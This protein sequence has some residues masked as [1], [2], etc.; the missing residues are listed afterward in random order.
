MIFSTERPTFAKH[1]TKEQKNTFN[2]YRTTL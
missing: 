2:V 1:T